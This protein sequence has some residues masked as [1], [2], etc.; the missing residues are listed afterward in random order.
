VSAT[1]QEIDPRFAELLTTK[2]ELWLDRERIT[3]E[4][5]EIDL[6]FV[7]P[8]RERLSDHEYW[9]WRHSKSKEK[10]EKETQLRD[11]KNRIHEINMELRQIRAE[12]K[13]ETRGEQFWGKRV[14]AKLDLLLAHFG[15]EWTDELLD[16]DDV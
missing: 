1:T 15:I 5:Q 12:A 3:G 14:E 4:I 11:V 13:V 16:D 10:R 2:R 7:D 8:A 6:Q 9:S